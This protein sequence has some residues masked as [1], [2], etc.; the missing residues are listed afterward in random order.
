VQFE[1]QWRRLHRVWLVKS[2]T[3]PS[4]SGVAEEFL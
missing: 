2:V 1:K 3:G 4:V